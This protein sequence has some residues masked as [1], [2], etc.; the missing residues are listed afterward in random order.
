MVGNAGQWHPLPA[1]HLPGSK[2][3]L[4]LSREG[5]R[6]VVKCLIE[7]AHAKQ[8]DFVLMLRFYPE[9]LTSGGRRHLLAGLLGLEVGLIVLE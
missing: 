4:K 3:D 7:I 1:T 2:S 5:T 6:V 8:E 9:V